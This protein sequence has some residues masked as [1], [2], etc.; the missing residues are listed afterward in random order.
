MTTVASPPPAR[1][2][3]VQARAAEL[4]ARA[5]WTPDELHAHWQE[6]LRT[7]VAHAVA[8]SPYYRER[9][10]SDAARGDIVLEQLP[11]LPKQTLM[12]EFDKIVTDPHLRL[13]ELESHLTGPDAGSPFRGRYRV[14]ASSGSSG[15]RGIVVHREDEFTTWIAAHL[16]F[17]ARV[18]LGPSTRLA[19]IGA[20]SPIHLS[21]QLFA[22]FQHGRCEAPRLSVLTPLHET[23]DTLQSCGAS[24]RF[25]SMPRPRCRSSR[26]ARSSTASF[27]SSTTWSGWRSSTN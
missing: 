9:L 6:R 3:L 12:R 18:G 5:H 24:A 8:A 22:V 16:P 25:R 27:R 15:L 13:A 10:G 23:V 1:L 2:E 7:L 14:F 17:F 21:K 4:A 26:R 11:T 19:A 20:P